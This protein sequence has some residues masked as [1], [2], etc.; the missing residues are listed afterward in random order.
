V[1]GSSVREDMMTWKL[2]FLSNMKAKRTNVEATVALKLNQGVMKGTGCNR[3][4]LDFSL[5]TFF[6]SRIRK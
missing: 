6:S 5:V 4:F 2:L 3:S 1:K